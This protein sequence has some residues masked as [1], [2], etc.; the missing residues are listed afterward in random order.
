MQFPGDEV[1]AN[2]IF[3]Q[4]FILMVAVLT[5]R[6]HGHVTGPY[7]TRSEDRYCYGLRQPLA[8]EIR[9]LRLGVIF[10]IGRLHTRWSVASDYRPTVG[11]G[12]TDINSTVV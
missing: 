10:N 9:K 4:K 8:I 6:C 1:I 2:F 11:M 5:A 12:S 3:G 7:S